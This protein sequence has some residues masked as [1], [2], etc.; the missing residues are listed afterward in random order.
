[1]VSIIMPVKNA[2]PW[3]VDCLDSIVNQTYENWELIAV[4]DHSDDLSEEIL[5]NYSEKNSRIQYLNNL[6]EGII[7]ALKLGYQK[8][9]GAFITRMD[10]D[11]L[12]P[13]RKLELLRHTFNEENKEHIATGMVKYIAENELGEGFSNYER[14][15]NNLVLKDSHYEEI[16]KECV[17]PSPCWMME[18][19]IFDKIGGF[20]SSVY[21]EDYDL[22]FRAYKAGVPVK[23]LNEVLH[24]WRDH[25]R[26]ASRND[27]NYMDNSFI[28]LKIHHFLDIDYQHERDLFLWGSGKKGKTIAQKLIKENV[29]FKWISENNK[30]IGLHIYDQEILDYDPELFSNANADLII[31]VAG[32]NDKVDIEK[33]ISKHKGLNA[34]W[35]N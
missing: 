31:S 19:S 29:D 3:L 5:Q 4:N 15:L 6:G 10:A 33:K 30:K 11:D 27:D 22:C 25:E 35:F 20:E 18:K 23:G 1:M 7:P 34:I 21:P 16:Y 14:W 2:S 12:M 9:N 26:R 8:S 24:I 32:P 13:E 28:D 17:I